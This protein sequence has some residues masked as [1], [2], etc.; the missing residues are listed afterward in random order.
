[1]RNELRLDFTG[2]ESANAKSQQQ[3]VTHHQDF[4]ATFEKQVGAATSGRPAA[5]RGSVLFR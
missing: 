3:S 1:M 2:I 4:H 5:W